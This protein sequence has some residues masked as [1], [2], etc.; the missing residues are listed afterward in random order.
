MSTTPLYDA[1]CAAV[2]DFD[3]DEVDR[4]GEAIA[5]PVERLRYYRKISEDMRQ[6]ERQLIDIR[7][8]A[9]RFATDH[10]DLERGR[11]ALAAGHPVH[12][13]RKRVLVR[14]LEAAVKGAT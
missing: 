13:L 6:A 12:R 7:I 3:I 14:L 9:E 2:R 4:G 1:A 8:R 10:L 11:A 5:D